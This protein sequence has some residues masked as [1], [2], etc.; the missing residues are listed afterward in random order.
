MKAP[1]G[2]DCWPPL[3]SSARRKRRSSPTWSGTDFRCRRGS[4]EFAVAS[5][6][7]VLTRRHG[8]LHRFSRDPHA[9]GK[10]VPSIREGRNVRDTL[11]GLLA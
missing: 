10:L 5:T 7:L 11:A 1:T 4:A 2:E 8:K 9:P 3:S 6:D